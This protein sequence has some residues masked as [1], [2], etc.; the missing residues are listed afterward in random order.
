MRFK[1]IPPAPDALDTLEATWRAVPLVP[2]AEGTC[3]ERIAGRIDRV[4]IDE[5]RRWL[6]LLRALDLVE[7]GAIG[8]VR[9]RPFPDAEALVPRFVDRVFGVRELVEHIDEHGP[10]DADAAFDAVEPRVPPWERHRNPNTW[11]T[12]WRERVGHL[13]DWGVLIGVF[14]R[15]DGRFDRSPNLIGSHDA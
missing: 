3:C 4:D 6:A 15:T 12:T 9:V 14:E 5:A 10:V 11:R 13:L 8:Y 7:K 2:E 1:A